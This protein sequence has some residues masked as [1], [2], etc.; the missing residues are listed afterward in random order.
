MKRLLLFGLTIFMFSLCS[1]KRTFIIDNQ[2]FKLKKPPGTVQI[3]DNFFVDKWE[4]SNRDYQE[5]L[6]WLSIIYGNTSKYLD[7]FPNDTYHWKNEFRHFVN[8]SNDWKID[9]N[10]YSPALFCDSSSYPD[11]PV[12]YISYEQA[13][14]YTVWRS[15]RVF[16]IILIE[17]G[18]LN[19]RN[20]NEVDST[21]Y[22]SIERYFNGK[23]EGI[24]PDF[25]IPYPH[26][27]LPTKA[28][29]EKIAQGFN[30]DEF[31]IDYEN[32]K[33]KRAIK[34]GNDLFRCTYFDAETQKEVQYDIPDF[35]W[36]YLPND[37]KIYS[38]IGNVSEM[39][40]E[41]GISKGGSF[42]HTKEECKISNDIPYEKPERWLGFRNVCTYQLWK[43]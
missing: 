12:R 28:E 41:K 37:Y 38:M 20:T 2:E 26:Y 6:Y 42:I 18:L 43:K 30:K 11:L 31:G 32:R 13:I 35:V 29:W 17:K 8:D 7:A 21:N 34:K 36:N 40:A 24:K 16:E 5:Y 25:S 23:I 10:N 15:D 9:S 14:D 4:L 3:E 39:I 19:A 22:F 27:R 33:I 1:P